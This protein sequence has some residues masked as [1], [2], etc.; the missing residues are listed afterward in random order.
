[1]MIY[2]NNN[3]ENDNDDDDYDDNELKQILSGFRRR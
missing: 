2:D 1:M 3:K